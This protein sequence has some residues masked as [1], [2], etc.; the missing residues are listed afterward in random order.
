MSNP[1]NCPKFLLR[2]VNQDSTQTFHPRHMQLANAFCR[3][4]GLQGA[5]TDARP[6]AASGAATRLGN[7]RQSPGSRNSVG[8]KSPLLCLLSIAVNAA[9]SAIS[10]T[11]TRQK[12]MKD[13]WRVC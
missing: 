6:P 1:A 4:L 10:Q 9:V 3:Y 11:F 5:R 12:R 13:L 8:T 7:S 2:V